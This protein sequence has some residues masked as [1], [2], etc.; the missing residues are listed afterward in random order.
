M[1]SRFFSPPQV[2]DR[3]YEHATL[4][5]AL[6]FFLFLAWDFLSLQAAGWKWSDFLDISPLAAYP[7]AGPL[8]IFLA[9][10][11]RRRR[12]ERRRDRFYRSLRDA[13]Q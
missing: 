13:L 2:P 11:Y 6:I 9:L 5:T 1:S 7:V 10:R 4:L 12:A 8:I 3:T